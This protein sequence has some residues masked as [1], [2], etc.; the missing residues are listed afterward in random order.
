MVAVVEVM[1]LV[2]EI[3]LGVAKQALTWLPFTEVIS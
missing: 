3:V 2:Q 1:A